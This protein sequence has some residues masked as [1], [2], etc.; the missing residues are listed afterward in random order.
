MDTDDFT[1]GLMM[2]C[3]VKI[4]Y[5]KRRRDDSYK[6]KQICACGSLLRRRKKEI[7]L[8]ILS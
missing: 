2:D 6:K 1:L 4:I 3:W 7:S 8:T 5:R